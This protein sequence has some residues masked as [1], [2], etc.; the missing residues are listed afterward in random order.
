MFVSHKLNEIL[1]IAE[2]VTVIRDGQNVATLPREEI[3]NEKLIYLMTG[4]EITYSR[5]QKSIQT[6]KNYLKYKTFPR[7]TILRIFP[8]FFIMVKYLV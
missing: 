7:V 6:Q 4:K 2:R 5:N 8:S 3:T 1:E